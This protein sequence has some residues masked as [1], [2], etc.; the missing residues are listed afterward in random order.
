MPLIQTDKPVYFI[1]LDTLS[2]PVTESDIRALHPNVSF[3]HPFV[4]PDGY[5]YVF[6]A[7][8]PAY[9]A[10]TERVQAAAP[11]LTNLG[12]WEQVWEVVPRFVDY[13]DA[14]DVLHTAAEQIAAETERLRLAS[15][16]QS[17]TMRQARLALHAAGLLSSVDTAIAS[18]QE[19]AKT[20]ALIEWEYASA[21]E[22]NAGLVPAMAAALG[23]SEADI[24]DLFIAAATL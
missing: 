19:P 4:P 15:V 22:R 24:D 20:A 9:N 18:M 10:I 23:M 7:P 13:T 5:A 21:V 6:P 12:H 17:V 2:W 11:V 8:Q 1:R 16:P 3:P 14:D